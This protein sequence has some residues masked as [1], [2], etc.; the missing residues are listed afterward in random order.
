MSNPNISHF[1]TFLFAES[2]LL[3]TIEIEGHSVPMISGQQIGK[4]LGY[5]RNGK[6]FCSQVRNIWS[7]QMEGFE[8]DDCAVVFPSYKLQQIC[9]DS[10]IHSPTFLSPKGAIACLSCVPG[11]PNAVA[12]SEFI[13]KEIASLKITEEE[14]KPTDAELMTA[15]ELPPIMFPV[16]LPEAAKSLETMWNIC[17]EAFASQPGVAGREFQKML[18]IVR[19][20][21]GDEHTPLEERMTPISYTPP[22]REP[23]PADLP[24]PTPPVAP[25][26]PEEPSEN[27]YQGLLSPTE[28]AKRLSTE[29]GVEVN[30]FTVGSCLKKIGA[31]G[32]MSDEFACPTHTAVYGKD[33]VQLYRYKPEVIPLLVPALLATQSIR[34]KLAGVTHSGE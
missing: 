23:D 7:R 30:S 5:S 31:H 29:L 4:I 24:I 9:P 13:A 20:I 1:K 25:A 3:T 6:Q 33:K 12:L 14:T 15:D 34:D 17:K 8:K 19:K 32:S 10:S 26:L 27:K 18:M 21:I 22:V 11:R 28:L 16:T 2:Y